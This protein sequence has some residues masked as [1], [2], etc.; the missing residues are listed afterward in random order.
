MIKP[1]L[2]NALPF[3]FSS[4]ADLTVRDIQEHLQELHRTDVSPDLIW[5]QRPT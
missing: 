1:E 4:F 2:L 3:E 5:W